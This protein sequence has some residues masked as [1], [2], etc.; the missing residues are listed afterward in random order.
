MILPNA[1][2][3]SPEQYRGVGPL[4]EASAR[5]PAAQVGLAAAAQ[6]DVAVQPVQVAEAPLAQR[7][8]SA[9][10]SVSPSGRSEFT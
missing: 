1:I 8:E 7:G 9:P 5:V 10:A 2:A 6:P 3:G 4:D